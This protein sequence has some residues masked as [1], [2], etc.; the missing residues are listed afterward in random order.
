[1]DCPICGRDNR[2]DAKFCSNCGN[3]LQRVCPICSHVNEAGANFCSNCGHRFAPAQKEIAG[4]VPPE[5]LMKISQARADQRMRG[6]RRTVTMLFADI[7]GSTA[8]AERLDPEEW[9]EIVNGAFEH[10]IRPV[11][12]YEGTLARLLGD[13]VLAFFGAP[14]AHEDDPVRAV[15]AGLEITEA[16]ASYREKAA[17]R[18]GLDIDVRVG[19][20]TGLVVVGEIGSDLRV[21]Y[22][23]IGDAVN[24]AARMEQTAEPG[25]VR[26]TAE[27]WELVSNH[28]EGEE[29]GPVDVKGKAEPVIAYRVLGVRADGPEVELVGPLVGRHGELARLRSL[30]E[31]LQEGAGWIAAVVGDAGLGKS[32]LLEEFRQA[33]DSDEL[34]W[35]AAAT[36]SYDSQVPYSTARQLL[37][38]W[39][40]LDSAQDP[41][42][43]VAEAAELIPDVDDAAAYLGVFT[44]IPLPE[45]VVDFLDEL[46]PPVLDSRIRQTVLSY[47]RA[48]A[49]RRPLVVAVEDLHWADAMSLALIEHMMA[50]TESEPL[51]LVIVMRPIRDGA[52]WHLHEV[53]E[54]EHP[55]RYTYLELG[56]L[57]EEAAAELL[58]SLVG[59]D[60]S[61]ET[62]KSVLERA[63]GQPPLHRAD[64]PCHPRVRHPGHPRALR[65]VLP[66]HRPARRPGPRVTGRG[67]VRLRDR[68]GV[69]PVHGGG[70]AR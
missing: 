13:A 50:V 34:G 45:S 25:T 23:A 10:L 12:R 22:T 20:N 65:A 5:T 26:V 53:A 29:I 16:M 11:Y 43:R 66:P 24:V 15:R 33:V 35:M 46:E 54:R 28:F 7:K 68:Q 47:M 9:T 18:W 64:R 37:T 30:A 52:A 32:R 1:M 67:P 39:W 21:D 56:T 44:G 36:E 61:P 17:Q 6:E 3:P 48:E 41:Y 70:A 4:Y 40:D 63:G 42:A 62:R 69:R 58:D 31:S 60:L 19:I 57:T 2:A 27:T 55:H 59:S 51:G 14:I 8:A 49:R 38:R